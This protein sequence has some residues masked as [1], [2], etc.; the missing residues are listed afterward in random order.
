[1]RCLPIF[2]ILLVLIPSAASLARPKTNDDVAMA[3]FYDNAKRILQKHWAK[4]SCCPEHTWC[5]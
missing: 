4:P 2:I 1:M 5:C 3:S